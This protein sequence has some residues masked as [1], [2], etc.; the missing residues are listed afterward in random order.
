MQKTFTPEDLIRFAYGEM[1]KAEACVFQAELSECEV[2]AAQLQSV[3]EVRELL[4]ISS[5]QP[6]HT[7]IQSLLNYSR[8]LQ[9]H[10]TQYAG[11][12]A[13]IVMN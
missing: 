2:T 10:T 8:S 9:I 5:G 6:R 12:T 3:N 1:E 4:E 13:E 11:V 7:T